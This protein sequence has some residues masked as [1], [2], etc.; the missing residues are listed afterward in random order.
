MAQ[1]WSS[2]LYDGAH[3]YVSNYG[4]ALLDWLTPQAGERI[5]DLGCGTGDLTAQI[6]ASGAQVVGLDASEAM[7]AAARKK[8]PA[9]TFLHGDATKLPTPEQAFDAVFSNAV[10]HWIPDLTPVAQG[11]ARVLRPGGRFVAEFGGIGCK[12]TIYS[13]LRAVVKDHGYAP[14]RVHFFRPLGELAT[15]FESAGFRIL[16]TEWFPRDTPLQGPDGMLNILKMFSLGILGN[17]PTEEHEALLAEAI[18][19]LRPHLLKAD[20]WHADYT[21]QRLLCQRL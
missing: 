1:Q 14:C 12:E 21:R 19:R 17:A 5:L 7:L 15:T 18:E 9:L 3:G 2:S 13:T 6:A 4:A 10:L 11:L 16:R 20:G 8:Y